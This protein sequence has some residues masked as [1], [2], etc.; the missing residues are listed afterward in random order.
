MFEC[1]ETLSICVVALA[2]S[3]GALVTAIAAHLKNDKKTG[4]KE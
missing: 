4:E 1:N 3:F 2:T